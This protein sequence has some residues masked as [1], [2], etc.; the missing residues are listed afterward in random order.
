[1]RAD[2]EALDALRGLEV[3]LLLADGAH[4]SGIASGFGADGA[5]LLDTPDGVVEHRSGLVARVH[6]GSLRESAA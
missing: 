1:M 3:E 4:V 2:A 6:G 5:L